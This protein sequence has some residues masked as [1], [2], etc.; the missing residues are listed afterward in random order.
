MPCYGVIRIK[1]HYY[2][3]TDLVEDYKHIPFQKADFSSE[4]L[5]E[6]NL[7]PEPQHTEDHSKDD[8]SHVMTSRNVYATKTI[9]LRWVP[10]L[11]HKYWAPLW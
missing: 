11:K 7:N 8:D 3:V 1:D 9:A 5:S 10:H 6:P 4:Y 2:T